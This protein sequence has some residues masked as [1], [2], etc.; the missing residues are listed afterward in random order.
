MTR[1]LNTTTVRRRKR[2]LLVRQQ[3]L[4]EDYERSISAVQ[5]ELRAL[6]DRCP[7]AS[8]EAYYNYEDSGWSCSDCGGDWNNH[9]HKDKQ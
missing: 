9:P 2:A 6:Q 5:K 8:I 1:E 3:R 7:H 4:H